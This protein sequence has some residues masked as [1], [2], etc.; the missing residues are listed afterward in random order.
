VKSS[1]VAHIN[2]LCHTYLCICLCDMTR[3]DS[4]HICDMTHL[5]VWH[6]VFKCA[7]WLVSNDSFI[8]ATWLIH[9]CGMTHSYV[10]HDS[11]MCWA[12]AQ[13][14]FLYMCDMTQSLIWLI[15]VSAM[16]HSDVW[17]DS[18]ICVTWLLHVCHL[19]RSYVWHD[20]FICLTWLIHVL[21]ELL[22]NVNFN[23]CVAWLIHMCDMIHSYEWHDSFVSIYITWLPCMFNC[24]QRHFRSVTSPAHMCDMTRPYF[25]YAVS[26]RMIWLI[27]TCDMTHFLCVTWHIFYVWHDAFSMYDMTH[28]LCVTSPV[29]YVGWLRFVGSFKS[30]VS[31]AE[32]SL[33]YRALLQKR[34]IILRSDITRSIGVTSHCDMTIFMCDKPRSNVWH[35]SFIHETWRIYMPGMTHSYT[36]Q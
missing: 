7:K 27:H 25:W 33:F 17:H 19:T 2:E 12:A 29:P 5:Y 3:H 18:F 4:I 35:G 15:C 9:T 26:R 16:A 11:F 31:F 24:C 1:Q 36:L 30:W 14:P 13:L 6:D 32:Y 28:F 22:P 23:I 20:Y 34:R 21:I 8:C 10:W